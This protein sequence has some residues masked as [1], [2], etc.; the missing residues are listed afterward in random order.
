MLLILL[1]AGTD[2]CII[3][4]FPSK[5]SHV[6]A[7]MSRTITQV[8]VSGIRLPMGCHSGRKGAAFSL[9]GLVLVLNDGT[10]CLPQRLPQCKKLK[11]DLLYSWNRP[12]EMRWFSQSVSPQLCTKTVAT[13]S[14]FFFGG[15]YLTKWVFF[16]RIKYIVLC[17]EVVS[18]L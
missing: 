16:S 9:Q 6:L 2:N 7:K 12:R 17:V 1:S 5:F 18:S 13:S 11:I 4:F 14:S 15:S 3:M 8:K 10:T